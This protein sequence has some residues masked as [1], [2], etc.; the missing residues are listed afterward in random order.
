MT[1]PPTPPVPAPQPPDE[2]ARLKQRLKRVGLV[3]VLVV[4]AAALTGLVLLGVAVRALFE[5]DQSSPEPDAALVSR[6]REHPAE[7][8]EL[9]AL[10]WADEGRRPGGAG[11]RA[12]ARK[13]RLTAAQRR[14]YRRLQRL[15]GIESVLIYNGEA[16][17]ATA[18]WGIVP[19]GW[20]QGY[21]W[22]RKAPS[23]LVD[24]TQDND[25]TSENVYRRLGGH[26][27]LFYET[28]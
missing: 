2:E 6:F 22:L 5:F 4:A 18:S 12:D 26:W 11:V 3:V 10:S 15:L 19:S 28:W 13:P 27:Y 17:F 20:S 24:D 8:R 7:F 16:D 21:T 14:S 9:L 25:S 1:A 23:S